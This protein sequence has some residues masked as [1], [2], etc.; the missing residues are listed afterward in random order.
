MVLKKVLK[1]LFNKKHGRWVTLF[2]EFHDTNEKYNISYENTISYK[3]NNFLDQ[4]GVKLIHWE[5][6][7]DHVLIEYR[8]F[9]KGE[10]V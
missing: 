7:N 9:D 1:R 10:D 2:K 6:I 5:K 4:P 8:Y 3:L